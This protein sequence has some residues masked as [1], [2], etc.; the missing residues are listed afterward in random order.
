MPNFCLDP[1]NGNDANDGS[2]WAL[3]WKTISSGAT[4]VRIAPG[5][6][7][8][9][10][11]SPDPVNSGINAIFTNQSATVTLASAL[12]LNID[13]CES[14]WTASTNVVQSN[15]S[16]YVMEGTY[17]QQF[18]IGGLFTTGKVAYK[19]LGS[20]ID[21]SAYQNIC[22]WIRTTTNT[23]ANVY[24]ICLCSDTIGNVIVNSL[25]I[26]KNLAGGSGF[27]LIKLLNGGALGDNI[28]SIAIYALSDP[29][30]VTISIDDIIACNNF[31][32][33]SVIGK[34]DG[35][36]YPIRSINENTITIGSVWNTTG[37]S[38][39]Y[40][41][42][43]E[44][45]S[46]YYRYN[47]HFISVPSSSSFSMNTVNVSGEVGNL[48]TF[49]GGWN[50]VTDLQDGESWFD[51]INGYGRAFYFGVKNYIKISKLNFVR[52]NNGIDYYTGDNLELDNVGT[53]GL[54]SNCFYSSSGNYGGVSAF[55]GN[56]INIGSYV[57]G[58]R[59]PINSAGVFTANF[60]NL[61]GGY[62]GPWFS[63]YAS[64]VKFIGNVVVK[65][66]S[67]SSY[68]V[69]ISG[70][71]NQF[72][73]IEIHYG[74]YGLVFNEKASGNYIENYLHNYGVGGFLVVFSSVGGKNRIGI[75][76]FPDTVPASIY[77][78]ASID[79]GISFDVFN[80]EGRWKTVFPNGSISDQIT[81]GQN[82]A[83]A[84]GSSGL[85]MYFDPS[86]TTIP[87]RYEFY[88]PCSPSVPITVSFY[89]KKT[90]ASATCTM[91]FSTSG[92][93]ITPVDAVSVSLTDTWVQYTSSS[94]S[95][96]Y[97]GYIRCVLEVLDGTVTGDIGVDTFSIC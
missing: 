97:T 1:V 93:G 90:S 30:I 12:T 25:T 20:I 2:T 62:A 77:G 3:A 63:C 39:Y 41:G 10:A 37:A 15:T 33:E 53:Y 28:Q 71:S 6:T 74:A 32:Q 18:A 22:L 43:T 76:T 51:L 80:T 56:I 52:G 40:F 72:R 94:M 75:S 45:V 83:W 4:L 78:L 69:A 54:G 14:A 95:P 19:A 13:M 8:K 86:S 87:V 92:C 9:I 16:A 26:D 50:T 85:C 17:S 73:N 79:A 82:V 44:S 61:G 55:T 7:I 48:I 68:S 59:I 66:T 91:T 64:S 46:F 42:T 24:Q 29:G 84:H 96:N 47:H 88:I 70:S 65:T 11:K 49:S 21:F 5:D 23:S 36:W 31:S 34:N 57:G 89:V 81:G 35:F 27:H 60:Y 38:S 67:S 58:I